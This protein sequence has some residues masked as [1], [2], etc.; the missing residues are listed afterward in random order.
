MLNGDSDENY[1]KD[2]SWNR[3]HSPLLLLPVIKSKV[4]TNPGSQKQWRRSHL[5]LSMMKICSTRGGSTHM[6]ASRR[7]HL[8]TYK[9]KIESMLVTMVAFMAVR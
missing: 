7:I 1:D 3:L 6:S 8:S 2:Q 4:I 9:L 5:A